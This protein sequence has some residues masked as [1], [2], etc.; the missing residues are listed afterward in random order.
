MMSLHPPPLH[1]QGY[2]GL[3][4]DQQEK[5]RKKRAP[6]ELPDCF[7]NIT[8]KNIY[9]R[10]ILGKEYDKG[11]KASSIN[12]GPLTGCTHVICYDKNNKVDSQPE[13]LTSNWKI[14]PWINF[15]CF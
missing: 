7:S 8:T 10:C 2:H 9:D 14:L 15:D 1:H 12:Q 4:Y 13:K 5:K 11:S 3:D 6:A